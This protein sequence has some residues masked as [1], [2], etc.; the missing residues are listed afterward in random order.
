MAM[1][2]WAM[3]GT[4]LLFAAASASAQVGPPAEEQA[5]AKWGERFAFGMTV[6][7]PGTQAVHFRLQS[8]PLP[9]LGQGG[10]VTELRLGPPLDLWVLGLDGDRID[11]PGA[12]LIG[13]DR[14]AVEAAASGHWRVDRPAIGYY[15]LT[16]PPTGQPWTLWAAFHPFMLR[17]DEPLT[18]TVGD[19]PGAVFLYPSREM[20]ELTE[21]GEVV[22]G[23]DEDAAWAAFLPWDLFE[24]SAPSVEI[25]GDATLTPGE[26]LRLRAVTHDPDRDIER[27][28]WHLPDGRAVE[29]ERLRLKPTWVEGWTARVEVT[30]ALGAT[31]AAEVE[32]I[33]PPLHEAPPPGAVLVQAED[34]AQEGGGAVFVTDRG[35]NMGRMITKWHQDAGHWLQWTLQAPRDGRYTLYARYATGSENA[36]RSLRIDGDAPAP[37]FEEIAFELT[38]GYGRAP[39]EWRTKRLGPPVTLSEGKHTLRMTNLG[40]GLALDYIALVPAGE[41]E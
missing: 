27:V 40:D 34:F 13:P 10:P 22:L 38:G 21:P 4:I 11:A 16:V 20:L 29:G 14:R 7:F 33:P 6:S 1:R 24:P 37:S 2:R 5:S 41:G 35:S 25:E 39:G 30:D 36:R 17:L 12:R 9:D 28:T 8:E 23:D 32:V 18:I 15:D 26:P 31:D 19:Q 3:V